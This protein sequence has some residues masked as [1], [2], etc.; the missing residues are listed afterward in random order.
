MKI[1]SVEFMSQNKKI[2]GKLHLPDVENPPVV[3]GSHGLEGSMESAK[4][5]I[6]SRILPD[7]GVAF[8]RFDHRGCG[9]SEGNFITD[10]SLEAR[11]QDMIHAV[12]YLWALKKTRKEL[13][14]FGSSLGGA[15]C[16]AAW[17]KLLDLGVEPQGA[18]VCAAP[19]DSSTITIIP[20]QATPDRPA[21]PLSFFKEN[22]LFNLS[23]DL[24]LMHH[25]LIFHGDHDGVVPVE[26]GREIHSKAGEPKKMIIHRNGDHQMSEKSHQKEFEKEVKLWVKACFKS[27]K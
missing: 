1:L 22:L 20:T 27:T 8:L 24:P 12:D 3:V 2:L 23:D 9:K 21:L 15:T 11:V 5:T 25:V 6:L 4:Q 18:V 14:L 7:M 19:V 16:I 26:N 13:M 17:K 10:T